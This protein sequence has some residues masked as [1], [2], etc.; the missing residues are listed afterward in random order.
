MESQLLLRFTTHADKTADRPPDLVKRD[1]TATAPN[2]LWVAD[3]TYCSTWEGWLYVAFIV[4]DVCAR[5]IVGWQ[6]AGHMRT[7]LVLDALEMAAWRRDPELGCVHH[8]DAGSQYT[9]IRY[10]D[11]LVAVGLAASIG[12]IGDSYDNAMAEALNGTFK[13][14]RQRQTRMA[15]TAT[16]SILL[17]AT[18]CTRSRQKRCIVTPCVDIDAVARS[19]SNE[20]SRSSSR[21]SMRPS[22]YST[23]VLPAVIVIVVSVCR[24][25]RAL[26]SPSSGSLISWINDAFPSV[27]MSKGGRCPAFARVAV[28]AESGRGS[29]RTMAHVASRSASNAGASSAARSS[30]SPGPVLDAA[31]MRSTTCSRPIAAAARMLCPVTSPTLATKEPSPTRTRSYQSP[32]TS[33]PSD[34]AVYTAPMS[35]CSTLGRSGSRL[36][37]NSDATRFSRMNKRA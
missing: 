15:M 4:V 14:E 32:P 36:C 23:S 35:S 13:A 6:I 26:V 7:D 28:H 9:S 29:S 11:R 24:R 12:T 27:S 17:G 2:Q 10:T 8:S 18:R 3:I 19:R 20:M 25:R 5:V 21:R 34:A 31:K 1:F 33:M 16:S 37:C 22:V 30:I